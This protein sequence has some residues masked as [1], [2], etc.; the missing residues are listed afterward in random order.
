MIKDELRR[1]IDFKEKY[2]NKWVAFDSATNSILASD[3]NL[4]KLAFKLQDIKQDY[5]LEKV[6]PRNVVFVPFGNES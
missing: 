5:T 1:L 4:K 6:L 2:Q 3:K